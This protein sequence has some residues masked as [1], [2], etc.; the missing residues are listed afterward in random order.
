LTLAIPQGYTLSIA[1]S[2][3]IAVRRYGFP[4]DLNALSFVAGAVTVFVLLAILGRGALAGNMAELP[5]RLRAL[6]NVVPLLVV[7]AVTGVVALV[8]SP[9]LGFPLAGLCGAGGYIL[10]L[11]IY[12]WVVADTR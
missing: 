1:G 7:G 6:I 3:A 2:F 10:L 8:A 12:M 5:M 4:D 11:S 9:G